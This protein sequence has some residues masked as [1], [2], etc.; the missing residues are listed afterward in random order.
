M[1]DLWQLDLKT[2]NWVRVHSSTDTG[3]P[4]STSYGAFKAWYQDSQV[5]FNHSAVQKCG[6]FG[7]LVRFSHSSRLGTKD[8][9]LDMSGGHG[10]DGMP[11]F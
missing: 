10:G 8:P 6:P 7:G 1:S 5:I 9:L 2:Q 3:A 11:I 4:V